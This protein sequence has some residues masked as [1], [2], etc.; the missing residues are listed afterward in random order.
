MNTNK[1]EKKMEIITHKNRQIEVSIYARYEDDNNVYP[2]I[3]YAFDLELRE[4]IDVDTIDVEDAV[5]Q[6]YSY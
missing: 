1:T 4:E 6:I 3:E 5:E 2:E